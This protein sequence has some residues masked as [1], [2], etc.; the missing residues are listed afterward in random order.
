MYEFSYLF[1]FKVGKLFIASHFAPSTLRDGYELIKKL[2][3]EYVVFSVTEDLKKMLKKAGYIVLPFKLHKE[4][5]GKETVKYLA[6]SNKKTLV[7]AL[8]HLD[9]LNI[10]KVFSNAETNPYIDWEEATY[11]AEDTVADYYDTYGNYGDPNDPYIDYGEEEDDY[12]D[13]YEEE[14][15]E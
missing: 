4:F 14:A 1:G 6:F 10:D 3:R 15:E 12:D 9:K 13:E 2:R 5:R 8:L 7:Y 11:T